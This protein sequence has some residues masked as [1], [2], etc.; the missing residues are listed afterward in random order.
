M[1]LIEMNIYD[2]YNDPKSL[3][4]HDVAQEKV[5][6]LIWSKLVSKYDL[7]L[8][9]NGVFQKMNSIIFNDFQKYE[10]AFATDARYAYLYARAILTGPFPKG[11]KAIATD[12]KYAYLYA[13]LVLGGRFKLGEPEIYRSSEYRNAY[14]R[15]FRIDDEAE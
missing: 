1:K 5:P 9:F 4:H 8:D 14:R 7:R 13:R 3:A 10:K 12:G 15:V 6:D 2:L 11:E